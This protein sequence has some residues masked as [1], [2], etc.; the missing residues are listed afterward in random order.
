MAA[1]QRITHLKTKA[2]GRI[3]CTPQRQSVSPSFCQY[4]ESC[5]MGGM[6]TKLFQTFSGP[7][8]LALTRPPPELWVL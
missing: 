2:L 7:F 6:A 1:V 3:P 8:S 4:P 5:G